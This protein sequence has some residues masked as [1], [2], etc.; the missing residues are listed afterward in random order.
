MILVTKFSTLKIPNCVELEEEKVL[1]L[2]IFDRI[3]K[4]L[5]KHV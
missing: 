4:Y 1:L 3:S 5:E 2:A